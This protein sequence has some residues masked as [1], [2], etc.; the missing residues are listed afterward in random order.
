M[1][2]RKSNIWPLNTFFCSAHLF[3]YLSRLLPSSSYLH[4]PLST[5][6]FSQHLY[7]HLLALLFSSKTHI[8]CNLQRVPK[9][10]VFEHKR[11]MNDLLHLCDCAMCELRG[12]ECIDVVYACLG[13]IWCK[14]NKLSRCSAVFLMFCPKNHH[15]NTLKKYTFCVALS[16]PFSLSLVFK[17]HSL[18]SNTKLHIAETN[19]AHANNM[20]LL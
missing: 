15:T 7:S 11:W 1:T 3:L 19:P 20:R 16:H 13:E 8:S 12:C 4:L 5:H 17:W 9:F 14:Q 6:C 10:C 2:W 18:A